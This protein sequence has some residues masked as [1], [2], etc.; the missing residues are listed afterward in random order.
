M[1]ETEG[2]SAPET[3]GHASARFDDARGG[4]CSTGPG[5][6]C[7]PGAAGGITCTG[8][9]PL[10]VVALGRSRGTFPGESLL[11]QRASR[12]PSGTSRAHRYVVDFGNT[13]SRLWKRAV[14]AEPEIV[15]L[16]HDDTDHIGGA[17]VAL[18]QLALRRP[19]TPTE[20]W[21][22]AD[23]LLVLIA[24]AALGDPDFEA[25]PGDA[26]LS[27]EAVEA[28]MT[29]EGGGVPGLPRVDEHQ[30]EQLNSDSIA[31]TGAM[32][33]ELLERA[34]RVVGAAD[35]AEVL[36][37]VITADRHER[38]QSLGVLGTS[39]AIATRG[40]KQALRIRRII[41]AARGCGT[42]RWFSVDVGPCP[43]PLWL[44]HGRPGELTLINAEEVVPTW[45]SRVSSPGVT[46]L[47]LVSLV[48]IQNE[49]ALVPFVWPTEAD[50]NGVI[51]WSDSTGASCAPTT[52][53]G[54]TPWAKAGLM[55]APHHGSRSPD[56]QAIWDG[57]S[58]HAPAA[59][60]LLSNNR[61]P[62]TV[63]YVNLHPRHAC[64][65]CPTASCARIRPGAITPTRPAR[66]AIAGWC[67]ACG[68][69]HLAER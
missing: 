28:L 44:A 31:A 43:G 18:R 11:V 5:S 13:T 61:W 37:G 57:R 60:V 64:T 40:A 26:D 52:A 65:H 8:T 1:T 69:W 46:L 32:V 48:T 25:T 53:A 6:S 49:R 58:A 51:I 12:G 54:P 7:D 30:K 35:L 68:E 33:D 4:S 15:I 29:G 42:V 3:H 2:C 56:H 36:E 14:D 41:A 16:T 66:D 21:L 10:W 22:P 17:A 23:W 50:R 59:V 24:S 67:P 27:P 38:L 39:A 34:E 55:T 63:E 20:I 19:T 62:T 9:S 45:R 47:Y